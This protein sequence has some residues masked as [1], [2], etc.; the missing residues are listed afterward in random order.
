MNFWSISSGFSLVAR[1]ASSAENCCHVNVSSSGSIAMWSSSFTLPSSSH[2]GHEHLAE[3]PRVD[4]AEVAALHELEHDVR[5]RRERLALVP[6]Q[7][8]PRHAEVHDEHVPAVEVHEEVL[9]LAVDPGDLLARQA[10]RELLASRVPADDPHRVAL[11]AH[12][13]LTDPPT[14]DVLLQVSPDDFDLGQLHEPVSSPDRRW[15]SRLAVGSPGPA[16]SSRAYACAGR[17][18]L[19]FLLRSPRAAAELLARPGTRWR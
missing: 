12:V 19:R 14:D 1:R 17:P 18:L 7:Q 6:A 15:S 3:R 5:V 10:I 8:L 9:A 16:S 2:A 11:R 13:G 4:E